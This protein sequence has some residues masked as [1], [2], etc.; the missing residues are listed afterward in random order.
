[1]KFHEKLVYFTNLLSDYRNVCFSKFFLLVP[2]ISVKGVREL[3]LT[4]FFHG[5][6]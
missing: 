1:M 4:D 6:A 3:D 2:S 5:T